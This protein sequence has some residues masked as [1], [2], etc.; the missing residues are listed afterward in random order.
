MKFYEKYM[1]ECFKLALKGAGKTSPNPLVGAVLIDDGGEIIS[2]GYHQTYGE[3]HAEKMAIANAGLKAKGATLIVNLE[4]CN[5][6]GKTPACTDLVVKSGIKKLV[7]AMK[8]PNPIAK[9]GIEKCKEAGIE[10]FEGVLE[11]EA[12]KLNEVFIK[13]HTQKKPFVALKTATTLDGKIATRTGQ[14]KWITN[15]KSRKLVQKLRNCYDGILVG[16]NTVK[17]D[18]PSLTC[19]IKNGRNP[20]RIVVDSNLLTN[21]KFKVY[22]DDGIMVVIA[23]REDLSEEKMLGFGKNVSFIKC[24]LKNGHVDLKFLMG[25]LF[26]RGVMSVLVEAGANLCGAFFESG[27]TDKLY[28]FIA[29]KVLGDKDSLTWVEGLN[30]KTLEHAK[31]LRLDSLKRFD[32]DILA[33]YYFQ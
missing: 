11:D 4:P 7:I 24:P 8:D 9:G 12:K 32:D 20:T 30:I 13:N 23:V 21:P 5:H 6:I 19:T 17:I 3:A 27:L 1:K 2:K 33:V 31:R 16:A 22:K 25:E 14:S 26:E 10:V 28:H 15:E 18:D 29:P